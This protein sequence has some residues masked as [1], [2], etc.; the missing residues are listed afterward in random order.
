MTTT[1]TPNRTG[2]TRPFTTTEVYLWTLM[3]TLL[4]LDIV[5][6]WYVLSEVGLRAEANPFTASLIRSFGLPVLIPQKVFI[7]SLALIARAFVS[8]KYFWAVPLG[9]I[10]PMAIVVPMNMAEVIAVA[11]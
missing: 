10:T 1:V 9:V 6:T 7:V 11:L 4:V 8:A 2:F 5:T 3:I